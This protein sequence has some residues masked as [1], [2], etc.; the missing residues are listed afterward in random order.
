MILR[1]QIPKDQLLF[2]ADTERIAKRNSK[3]KT[4]EREGDT[5]K[6]SSTTYSFLINI[7]YEESNIAEE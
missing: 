4:K 6:E 1:D 3:T 5:R 7:F 2:E